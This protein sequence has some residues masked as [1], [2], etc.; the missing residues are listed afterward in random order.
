MRSLFIHL[1]RAWHF[2]EP[3]ITAALGLL[4]KSLALVLLRALA[5]VLRIRSLAADGR[6]GTI[7][8]SPMDLGV[9]GQ[10]MGTGT[11][12]PATID[13][14]LSFFEGRKEGTFIDVGANIGLTTI[15]VAKAGVRCIGFEPDRENYGFLVR[16]VAESGVADRVCLHNVALFD[17]RTQVRFERSDWN[18][19]DHRIRKDDHPR[20]GLY[21]EQAREVVVVEAVRLDDLVSLADLR[22]PFA[23]KMDAEGAEVNV[24]RGGERL[25]S[26]VDLLIFE[27][28]PYLIR[29]MGEDER[30]LIDFASRH[31]RAGCVRGTHDHQKGVALAEIA[32]TRSELEAFSKRAGAADHVDVF[33]LK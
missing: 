33:L 14:V 15:P 30:Y 8:G 20:R 2:S 4:P 27:F 31:F 28:C 24:V 10:Y 26:Q 19:G 23:V 25:L 7:V 12:A 5:K 3:A 9:L 6:Y 16:N 32:E 29:R 11:Y 1:Q 17:R 22:R 13:F 21:G 18:H